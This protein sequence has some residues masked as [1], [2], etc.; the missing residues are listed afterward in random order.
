MTD[1]E[2]GRTPLF[3]SM[4][5]PGP[6]FLSTAVLLVIF[7]ALFFV[8]GVCLDSVRVSV[9]RK[10][11]T[12]QKFGPLRV[13]RPL[14]TVTIKLSHLPPPDSWTYIET[15]VSQDEG[16]VLF[17]FGEEFYH[18]SSD[19]PSFKDTSATK[20]FLPGGHTYGFDFYTESARVAD[21]GKGVRHGP[22]IIGVAVD[23][24]RG[25]SYWHYFFAVM[26]LAAGAAF[27][28]CRKII[29]LSWIGFRNITAVVLLAGFA[30]LTWAAL[31]GIDLETDPG[32]AWGTVKADGE[33]VEAPSLREGSLGGPDHLGGSLMGG[34]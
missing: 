29:P 6:S 31:T 25:D 20:L 11:L 15:I 7:A 4:R 33:F 22:A 17:S 23:F 19:P 14:E 21:C 2:K 16:R 32:P 28:F 3:D 10:Q 1:T 26:L 8:M 18:E 24:H 30:L 5:P 13:A 9:S 12:T 27:F 34:K